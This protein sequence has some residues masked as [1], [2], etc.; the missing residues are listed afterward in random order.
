GLCANRFGKACF[1]K[2]WFVQRLIVRQHITSKLALRV[3]ALRV[4]CL[5]LR[6]LLDNT[7][8]F[9][10]CQPLFSS[11]FIFSLKNQKSLKNKAFS[12]LLHYRDKAF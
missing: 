7:T 10:T 12:D 6:Q 9:F 11:F 4:D 3:I 5:H 2:N 1:H 8:L